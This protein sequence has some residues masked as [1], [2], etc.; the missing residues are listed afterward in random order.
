MAG[1]ARST[2]DVLVRVI[3]ASVRQPRITV[4]VGSDVLARQLAFGSATPVP[5]RPAGDTQVAFT[6]PGGHA[7]MPVTLTVGSVHTIVV[8]DGTSGLKIDNLTDAAASPVAPRGG[9]ATGLGGTAPDGGPAWRRGW[10]R[11]PRDAAGCYRGVRPAQVAPHR[12]GARKW[13]S[14]YGGSNNASPY[15]R[16]SRIRPIS[17]QMKTAPRDFPGAA[18][19]KCLEA[20]TW[21]PLRR[22]GQP[23]AARAGSC[24]RLVLAPAVSSYIQGKP[25]PG[26]GQ[27]YFPARPNVAGW[28]GGAGRA[29][30]I[31]ELRVVTER[32][33]EK[34]ERLQCNDHVLVFLSY[35]G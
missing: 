5:G 3:Q 33:G 25:A 29:R 24:T 10:P 20:L 6:A 16:L 17:T 32:R 11:S 19:G 15:E 31:F 2:G 4:S 7:A 18:A 34:T 30:A 9:A 1:P 28:R 13:C 23:Q 8:L 35:A 27:S 21:Q 22:S 26:R 14:R 12:R